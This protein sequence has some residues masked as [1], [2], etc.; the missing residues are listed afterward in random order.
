MVDPDTQRTDDLWAARGG[1][2][3]FGT[4]YSI[5]DLACCPEA[6]GETI[7]ASTG[8]NGTVGVWSFTESSVVPHLTAILLLCLVSISGFSVFAS[9]IIRRIYS[10]QD[11][12]VMVW[13][14]RQPKAQM[15]LCPTKGGGPSL[16]RKPVRDV[17]FNP[18]LPYSL[19]SACE[20]GHAQVFDIR[21]P[22]T[23]SHKLLVSTDLLT[24]LAWHPGDPD[25][26]A[27]GGADQCIRVWNLPQCAGR[28]KAPMASM[29]CMGPVLH[30]VW[31]QTERVGPAGSGSPLL[32]SCCQS[33][34]QSITLW[35][36]RRPHIPAYSLQAHRDVINRMA[37]RPGFSDLLLSG[38]KDCTFR[39]HMVHPSKHLLFTLSGA[40]CSWSPCGDLA[41]ALDKV[42][43]KD[44][45]FTKALH[46]TSKQTSPSSFTQLIGNAMER[47]PS[48][49]IAIFQPA[50]CYSAGTCNAADTLQALSRK[51]PDGKHGLDAALA[52]CQSNAEALQ[53]LGSNSSALWQALIPLLRAEV[54]QSSTSSPL[55]GS[56]STSACTPCPQSA[57]SACL[58]GAG[59]GPTGSCL[60]IPSSSTLQAV[61]SEDSPHGRLV[62]SSSSPSVLSAVIASAAASL[63][64]EGDTVQCSALCSLARYL[65]PHHSRYVEKTFPPR[66]VNECTLSNIEMLQKSGNYALAAH[67]LK[68]SPGLPSTLCP[69]RDTSVG[70]ACSLCKKPASG[71]DT[72][73]SAKPVTGLYL[74]FL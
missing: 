74:G 51:P 17:A 42:P 59:T 1:N 46:I 62:S 69:S 64:L 52:I 61:G 32:A 65:S 45:T 35:D 25:I 43:V 39:A 24:T 3:W 12:F 41:V 9:D 22:V 66:L 19:A 47:Q 40:T 37:W 8:G 55:T 14:A 26:L 71:A 29:Q 56:A 11:G 28:R 34:D 72:E 16:Q 23:A 73:H 50:L 13:D 10:S 67:I 15:S 2:H 60:G 6:A 33:V 36:P 38:S 5:T 27:T 57:V 21:Q 31:Q 68:T 58:F 18:L 20:S 48:C 7:L 54:Q 4:G 70:L 49:N 53:A 63:C 30:V 44:K